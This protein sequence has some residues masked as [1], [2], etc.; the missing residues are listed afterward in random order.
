MGSPSLLDEIGEVAAPVDDPDDS[1]GVFPAA[2]KNHL[3]VHP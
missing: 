3:S 2:I 1:H